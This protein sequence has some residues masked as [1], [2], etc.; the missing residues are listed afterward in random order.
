MVYRRGRAVVAVVAALL[1]SMVAIPTPAM[2][3]TCNGAS[4]NAKDPQV[5]GCNSDAI[6]LEHMSDAGYYLELRYSRACYA[7]WVR[8]TSDGYW[9]QTGS[10]RLE[11]K[12]PSSFFSGSFGSG[13]AGQK[14]TRMY[15]F[16]YQL[17][18]RLEIMDYSSG[19]HQ[20]W[21]TPWR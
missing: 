13:E 1:L 8:V 15:N 9:S 7:A 18:G 2:A 14:W 11:R 20:I 3:A 21:W 16:T 10:Y 5:E 4:C 6:T 17:R 12:T 19:Y